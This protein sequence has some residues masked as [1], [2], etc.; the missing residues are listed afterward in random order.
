MAENR[1]LKELAAPD[2]NQQPLCITFPTLDATTFELKSGLIHLLPTFHGLAGEDPHKHLKEFHVVCTSMKPTGVTEEQIKLR[3]FPFSLKDSAKD[4]LY[5]LPSGSITIWNEMK[6]LFLEKYF[7][8]SRAANIRKEICGVRQQNGESLH[9]YWERFKKLCAS[10]PHHQISEQLLIQYFYEGLLPTERSMIDAASGGALVDKTP[11]TAR[12]LIA[13]MA[14]NSQQF[15]TRLDPPSKHVNEVNISSLEQQIASLTSLVR[16]MAVGNMQTEKAC[17]IC[18][19]VGHPT[20]MCP[21]LQ[22]E[23]TEQV[24]A[25]GGFP[26][27]PQRKYDPYSSTYNQGWRDHPNLSYRNPQVNQP[28]TQNRPNFQQYQ[29]PYPPRQQPGQT[30]NSGMSLEDIVKTL[31]TNTL[32]FQQETKQFQHEARASIQSLDNQM[33]QMATAISRLEAQSSG[34]LP[35]QTV[36]NPRENASAIVL[37]S[38]KEVEIPTKA[39]PASS[40]QE[41]EKNIV[42]DRNVSNDDDVP[43]H[44]FPPLSAYKPVSPFPQALAESRKDEQNKDLYETFRRCEVNIPLL[45]AIKQVPRYAKFLKELCTIKRK[46]KLKGCETVRVGENISAVIQR[47][48]PAKCKDPGMFTIP[49]MIGNTRFEKAMIDLGAS[50]NVMS[51][52]IYASLKPGP[53][54]KTG[55]VIQLADRS[56]A[57]PKG[58]V[59]DVLVQVNDLVFPADFYVLDMENG[60]QTAPILLGRPFL[61]TSKTKIDVHSGTLTMEFDGEIIKF[62]IYDAMKY[63]GDDNPVYSIDVIDSLAQEVFELDGKDGLEVAISKH[64]ETENEELVLSTDLQEIVA[65]LNNFPKLQQSGNVSYIALPVSNGRPLPSVLQAPIPDLKPLP[66]HLKYVFL[67][68]RGTLPVIISN[69]LSALQ[70]EKLVQILKEHQTAIGWTIADIK[71]ISPTTC[72]HR[73]LLEEGAKPSRQPQRRLNPPIMDVVKKEILKLLEVGVIYP[74]SD[75]NWVSPVQVVPKKTGIT[76]V[77]NQ[78]DELVPTRIQNGWRVCIDY[79]KLN[80]VTRKDH[81]PL[82]FIDQMLERLAGHSYYC[83]L[84]G[85]SGYTRCRYPYYEDRR[86]P[87]NVDR[88]RSYYDDRCHPYNDDQQRE[89]EEMD[90]TE[91]RLRLRRQQDKKLAEVLHQMDLIRQKEEAYQLALRMESQQRQRCPAQ[92]SI[93]RRPLERSSQGVL[94]PRG[95]APIFRSKTSFNRS[96]YQER[97]ALRANERGKGCMPQSMLQG[98]NSTD[99]YKCGGRGHSA[100]VC[101]TRDQHSTLVCEEDEIIEPSEVPPS[102]Q[103]TIDEENEGDEEETPTDEALLASVAKGASS[104]ISEVVP[105]DFKSILDDSSNITLESLPNNLPLMRDNQRTIDLVPRSSLP[106]LPACWLNPKEHEEPRRQVLMHGPHAEDFIADA[107]SQNSYVLTLLNVEVS[108]IFYV[109]ELQPYDGHYVEELQPYDGRYV[110]DEDIPPVSSSLLRRSAPTDTIED[111]LVDQIMPTY[112]GGYQKFFIGGSTNFRLHMIKDGGSPTAEPELLRALSNAKFDGVESFSRRGELM[113]EHPPWAWSIGSSPLG[114]E[115]EFPSWVCTKFH[116]VQGVPISI[117]LS[118]IESWGERGDEAQP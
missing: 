42:A 116:G 89:V 56:N 65:A 60:D 1:T 31:A 112:R 41:K 10:C 78:N 118:P 62:N 115:I 15:G 36:V 4:W 51:Y 16:Q 93:V 99:C 11:E 61:K 48:L 35:S 103:P 74:I 86:Y 92:T 85:Y 69:K 90:R 43:K 68:D 14:A 21:T 105:P 13:N 44:K 38:G 57:Y 101:P 12:N 82:P 30:S 109:E 98:S 33:G 37:R 71:G 39:T 22:E 49:C 6:R 27:Q 80:A 46:Q 32:Q 59:E 88:C 100:V 106:N 73:I 108:P 102:P 19:V 17:G 94:F 76:V 45:D 55:V 72:M 111:I 87:Y 70:E 18:S 7:P 84:D 23:P 63:P 53:L 3:A 58:V 81:F 67:G 26:G 47:K 9:E 40:K 75:S 50:I 66:S 2:L 117:M 79:R 83:F 110:K 5:Y 29:Q 20:D 52:S 96:A 104:E 8:A 113:Q 54:N 34:K 25:A 97:G 24:N 91:A 107:L 114:M 95:N 28:A 77:K 64:L